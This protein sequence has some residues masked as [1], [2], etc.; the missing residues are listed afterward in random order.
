MEGK[1]KMEEELDRGRNLSIITIILCVINIVAYVY[2]LFAG[3]DYYLTGG[4]N[5][6]R[7]VEHKEYYRFLTCM[8]LH[9]DIGH[10]AMNML[11]LVVSG[12]LVESYIG[13]LKTTIIYFLSGFCGSL[14]SLIFHASG[15]P[16]YSVG[17]SGAIFGL[18]LAA[19]VIQN[20][21]AGKSLFRALAY[22]VIYAIG[23]WSQGID[24]LGHIGGALGGLVTAAILCIHFNEEY[25]ERKVST[26]IGIG[27]TLAISATAYRYIMMLG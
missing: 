11:A 6:G 10:I 1:I 5:Y 22:G 21:K 4:M 8:F 2:T 27:F 7:I 23:T 20:K 26:I 24:L 16:V 18:M 3:G 19:A 12:M 25:K 17:A 9:G 13:S 14:L 15:E